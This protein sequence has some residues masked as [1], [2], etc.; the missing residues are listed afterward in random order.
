MVSA[1]DTPY[2]A[3]FV[4][5]CQ[6]LAR[7]PLN[8]TRLQEA[9]AS[10]AAVAARDHPA[11]PW[12][13]VMRTGD[14]QTIPFTLEALLSRKSEAFAQALPVPDVTI[15]EL[16]HRWESVRVKE[17]VASW[18]D[19]GFQLHLTKKIR[20]GPKSTRTQHG[21]SVCVSCSWKFGQ[22][23]LVVCTSSDSA[24]HIAASLRSL[25]GASLLS[26]HLGPDGLLLLKWKTNAWLLI[27]P[28][29]WLLGEDYLLDFGW[30]DQQLLIY[31]RFGGSFVT[32][33]QRYY[34][35]NATI[36]DL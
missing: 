10:L 28:D 12:P 32:H 31:Y 11:M 15:K 16:L 18:R 23:Q 22:E 26:S 25:K 29:G 21:G 2:G 7:R 17:V 33:E 24:Q 14:G 9:Y 27:E 30:E 8:I 1:P 36:D 19:A 6:L 4:Q 34:D 20:V 35:E 3:A 5:F 13:T